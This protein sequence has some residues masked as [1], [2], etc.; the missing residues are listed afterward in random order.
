MIV[1]YI[2]IGILLLALI[3]ALL[4]PPRYQIERSIIIKRPQPEVMSRVSDFN[5]YKEWNPWQ[6]MEPLAQ[7]IITGTAKKPGHKY[8]WNG[9]KIGS[10][11]LTLRD[12]DQKHI[13]FDLEFLRPWKSK[14][15][16]NWLF[17]EW[18]ANETKVTWQNAGELPF[19]MARLMWPMIRNGLD[20]QFVQGLNN[21]KKISEGQ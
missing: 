18:G 11:S 7:P 2:L 21:L 13:R 15:T 4:S 19:P 12:I 5:Y 1:V 17:E 3:V 10:G 6:Q 14:A 20:K 9:K 16:D 8:E